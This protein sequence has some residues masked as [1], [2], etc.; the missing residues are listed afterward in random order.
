MIHALRHDVAP[1]SRPSGA[2]E[3]ASL[4]TNTCVRLIRDLRDPTAL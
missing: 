4:L 3:R 1:A 2:C